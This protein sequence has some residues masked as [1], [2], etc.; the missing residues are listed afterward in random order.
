MFVPAVF[1]IMLAVLMVVRTTDAFALKKEEMATHETTAAT[2]TVSTDSTATAT[3]AVTPSAMATETTLVAATQ[4]INVKAKRSKRY[5]T[6][7]S[8][9]SPAEAN[10]TV[11][12]EKKPSELIT[13]QQLENKTNEPKSQ[14]I[15]KDSTQEAA[16]GKGTEIEIIRTGSTPPAQE[17]QVPQKEEKS[18]EPNPETAVMP[19][20]PETK[21]QQEKKQDVANKA[22]AVSPKTEA[23]VKTEA[24]TKAKTAT[25]AAAPEPT[26]A[27]APEKNAATTPTAST[28]KKTAQKPPEKQPVDENAEKKPAE[29]AAV[30][31]KPSPTRKTEED[32][33]PKRFLVRSVA[34]TADN[35]LVDL[36]NKLIKHGYHPVILEETLDSGD[37]FF[38]LDMG[39]FDDAQSAVQLLVYLRAYSNDFFVL[40]TGS[41]RGP[42]S[43]LLSSTKL[44]EIFPGDGSGGKDLLAMLSA[45]DFAVG[46]YDR[47]RIIKEPVAEATS[48]TGGR[49]SG[50][51][52]ESGI[53]TG[54]VLK[55]TQPSLVGYE[56]I[57][58]EKKLRDLAWEMR[59]R[60][61]D[62]YLEDETFTKPQGVLVG[63]FQNQDEALDLSKELQGYGYA[64]N[65]IFESG[66]EDAYFVY[67]DP[68]SSTR[69]ITV[70]KPDEIDKFRV[71]DEFSPPDQPVADALL[72][73]SKNGS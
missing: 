48:D 19:A 61:F 15:Q 62:V 7:K 33:S 17:K 6:V 3:T 28:V 72:N 65:V 54:P 38:Y 37:K 4:T 45:S 42:G 70:V 60:G 46:L 10:E 32:T 35:D 34:L 39:R 26:P 56:G 67:A 5:D 59:G 47:D 30:D 23:K 52:N 21:P 31:K 1:V 25:A 57:P 44:D 66:M 49:K 2:D 12:T 24:K 16:S 55:V 43:G 14:S 9:T 18:P 27:T 29:T 8:E 53:A 73:L 22:T 68:D 11:V 20:A 58:L 36:I 51:V 64:V 69:E 13:E 50:G 71:K 63:I 41:A 40:G